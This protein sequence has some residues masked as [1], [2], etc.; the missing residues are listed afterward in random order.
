LK[1]VFILTEFFPPSF[2]ATGQLLEELSDILGK[3]F[4]IEILTSIKKNNFDESKKSYKTKRFS[5]L[6]L[7]KNNKI[8]RALNGILFFFSCFF[9]LIPKSKDSIL[10]IVSNPPF[11]PVLGYLF[12]KLKKQKYVYLIHDQY[13]EIAVKLGYLKEKSLITKLWM[14]L[15]RKVFSTAARVIS[16]GKLMGEHITNIYPILGKRHILKTIPNWSIKENIYPIAD[17]IEIKKKYK[18]E[19]KFVIQYSGNMGLFHGLEVMID[20]ADILRENNEIIFQFIGDGGKKRFLQDETAKRKLKNVI[21][22]E[23]AAKINLNESLNCA[24]IGIVA[25]D[26]RADNLAIPSKFYG[27]IAAGLPIIGLMNRETDIGKEIIEKHLGYIFPSKNPLE[28]ADKILSFQKDKSLLQKYSKNA[29][30]LF[31]EKYDLTTVAHKY[32]TLLIEMEIKMLDLHCHS[33]TS[34]GLLSPQELMLK[35]KESGINYIAL[36]DHDT[37]AGLNEARITAEKYGINLINGVEISCQIPKG[38]L[39]ILGLFVNPLDENLNNMFKKLQNYRRER[40]EKFLTKLKEIGID[41][42]MDELLEGNRKLEN[43]GKPNFARYLEKKGIVKNSKDAYGKYLNDGGLASVSKEKIKSEDAISAIH[44]AGGI[45]VLAHPD[46]VKLFNFTEFNNFV[47]DLKNKGLDGI[48]VY[49]SNYNKKQIKFYKKIAQNH[50]LVISGGSDFHG[51]EK[52]RNAKLGFYGFKKKIP[53]ELLGDI[54]NYISNQ[55]R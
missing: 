1:K 22:Q 18:I 33:N 20:V 44:G 36:T 15:N 24:D 25:L 28:I 16:L 17:K 43:I 32:K 38:E 23:Y 19:N 11:L 30:N 21:F 55:S 49:Y 39:H 52:Y 54:K 4:D 2:A 7:N 41:I 46:Q 8:G 9:Y 48:E 5:L 45:A 14:A 10:L 51:V 35:A 6:K 27:I 13:P 31:L 26:S 42:N 37:V 53:P 29:L 50:G 12:F 40:N 3:D 47:I 34:D